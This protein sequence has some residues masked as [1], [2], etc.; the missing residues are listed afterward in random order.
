MGN[1][2][3]NGKGGGIWS[4][5]LPWTKKPLITD[6]IIYGNEALSD[7]EIWTDHP[8]YPPL[9]CCIKNWLG[10]G[11]GNISDD[12]IFEQGSFGKYYLKDDPTIKSQCID[13]GSQ[14]AS[15]AGLD[16]RTTTAKKGSIYTTDVDLGYHYLKC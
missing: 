7:S 5:E 16:N 1:K 10:T 6:C 9:Y 8:F 2:A 4:T 11:T 12:P 14:T 13:A 3:P 15:N